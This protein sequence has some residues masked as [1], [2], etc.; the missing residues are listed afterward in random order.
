[1]EIQIIIHWFEGNSRDL[2]KIIE[3]YESGVGEL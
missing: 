2:K 3:H 1:M